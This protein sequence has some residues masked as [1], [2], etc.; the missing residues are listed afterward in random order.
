MDAVSGL[1]KIF[2]WKF[3]KKVWILV[4][5]NLTN[6]TTNQDR[7]VQN[8]KLKSDILKQLTAI[9]LHYNFSSPITKE[10]EIH[11]QA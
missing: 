9:C 5:K 4:H 10:C 1:F 6:A 2:Y 3:R 11:L 8:P 7:K